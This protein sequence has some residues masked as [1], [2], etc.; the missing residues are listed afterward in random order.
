M[1][2][3]NFKKGFT[4]LPIMTAL[5]FSSTPYAQTDKDNLINELKVLTEQ[6]KSENAYNIA[7][8]HLEEL[9]GTPL[10]DFYYG[11][12][13]VD[14]GHPGE[15]TMALE[16]VLIQYPENDR[17]RLEYARGMYLLEDNEAAKQEF[18]TVL[19]KEPPEAVAIKI[20][21]YLALI[22]K[23]EQQYKVTKKVYAQI[24]AGYDS[25]LN[26][27]PE[28]QLNRVELTDESL[29]KGDSYVQ[30]SAGATITKPMDKTY[31]LFAKGDVNHKSY[32][33]EDSFNN[34]TLNIVG[35][36]RYNLEN[37]DRVQ[38][39]ARGQHYR[40]DGSAFRNMFSLSA[41]YTHSFS[42]TLSASAYLS[43]SR[44]SYPDSSIAWRDSIQVSTGAS[45][46][47]VLPIWNSPI[48]FSNLY[49]GEET[50]DDVTTVSKASVE[51][52]FFGG[53]IGLQLPITEKNIATAAA[54]YQD[55]EYQGRDWLYNTRRHDKYKALNLSWRYLFNDQFSVNL[56]SS[57]IDNSSSIEL[58]E[59]D[60]E[61]VSIGVKYEY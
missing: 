59:Y 39:T 20:K 50:P 37:K 29:G 27:A 10:F 23:R 6:G 34:S 52:Q 2:W 55:T 58:Y 33:D 60:R 13:A 25:N 36:L 53:S 1:R 28:D 15:G 11:L 42:N 22:E 3:L 14:S 41:D 18:N 61:V 17:V 7:S 44:F 31:T 57:F 38:V 9:E 12:A 8:E 56:N 16:R 51:K 35:G 43:A 32:Q 48:L 4:I 21:R 5:T 49:Y 47:K 46:Y 26:S 19:L 54:I 30:A 40:T 45:V 24:T